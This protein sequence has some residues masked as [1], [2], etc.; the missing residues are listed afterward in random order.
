MMSYIQDAVRQWAWAYGEERLDCEWILSDYDSWERNPHYTGPKGRH[1]ED[2]S[3]YDDHVV[4][5]SS[6]KEV[7]SNE[8]LFDNDI[9]F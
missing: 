2:Y 6:V 4:P 7:Y 8:E 1:P 3:D 9:P 5:D